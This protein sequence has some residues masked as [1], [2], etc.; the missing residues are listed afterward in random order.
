MTTHFY[1]IKAKMERDMKELE[2]ENRLL[3]QENQRLKTRE[4]EPTRD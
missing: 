4:A 1:D 2:R 3:R